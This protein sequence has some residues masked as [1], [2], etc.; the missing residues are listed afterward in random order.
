M[1]DG[2][3]MIDVN[4][5]T[6][7]ASVMANRLRSA[8]QSCDRKQQ[9]VA[10]VALVALSSLFALPLLDP[11]SQWGMSWEPHDDAGGPK[12]QQVAC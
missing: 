11:L 9:D 3:T 1:I 4:G 2:Q 7:M 6:Y 12:Q 8:K 10:L 5:C